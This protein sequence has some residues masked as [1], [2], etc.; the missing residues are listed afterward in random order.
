MLSQ[1]MNDHL[2][3]TNFPRTPIRQ[4]CDCRYC[5]SLLIWYVQQAVATDALQKF[6]FLSWSCKHL[7]DVV[8]HYEHLTLNLCLWASYSCV[9]VLVHQPVVL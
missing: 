9:S 4:H 1:A 3:G 7:R 5:S 2:L 8:F 6:S